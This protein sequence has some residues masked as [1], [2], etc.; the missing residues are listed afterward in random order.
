MLPGTNRALLGIVTETIAV[1]SVDPT[2]FWMAAL[3]GLGGF[4]AWLLKDYIAYL[5]TEINDWKTL[6][7]K[8]ADVTEEAVKKVT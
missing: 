8:G 2:L 7:F 6:A 3:V 4:T 1:P 5:K